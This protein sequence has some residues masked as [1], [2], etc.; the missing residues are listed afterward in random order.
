M[1]KT[2]EDFDSVIL[3]NIAH[4]LPAAKCIRNLS[5]TSRTLY[6]FVKHDGWRVF[7]LSR[8]PSIPIPKMWEDGAHA[9]TTLSRNLDRRA[10]IATELRPERPIHC[11]PTGEI[12]DSIS[13]PQGQSMGYQA[14]VDSFEEWTGNDWASRREVVAWGAGADVVLKKTMRRSTPPLENKSVARE[15]KDGTRLQHDR[16]FFKWLVYHEPSS[17]EGRDDVTALKLVQ[18]SKPQD[19]ERIMEEAVIGRANGK[20]E[21]LQLASGTS[22]CVAKSYITGDSPVRSAG[23]SKHSTPLLA[24]GFRNGQVKV[25]RVH[26]EGALVDPVSQIDCNMNSIDGSFPWSAPTDFLGSNLLGVGLGV[27]D[28]PVA[29]YDVGNQGISERPLRTFSFPKSRYSHGQ[30]I[31]TALAQFPEG[32]GSSSKAFLSGGYDGVIRLHDLRSPT[33]VSLAIHDN[34]ESSSI[35]SLLTIG[36]ERIMAGMG[37]NSL[38]NIFDMRMTGGRAYSYLDASST[39]RSSP[40]ALETEFYDSASESQWTQW[41][42]EGSRDNSILDASFGIF[43]QRSTRRRSPVY[44]LSRPSPSSPFLFVGTEGGVMQLNFTSMYDA[45]PDSVFQSG[46]RRTAKG[47]F[48]AGQTWRPEKGRGHESYFFIREQDVAGGIRLFK[49]GKVPNEVVDTLQDPMRAAQWRE[50]HYDNNVY[51]RHERRFVEGYDE[52]LIQS[53]NVD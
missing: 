52:R 36:R 9:L 51:D 38:V 27:P 45:N 12:R 47:R 4:H 35:F 18:P 26:G 21:L 7:D 48:D 24:A 8:F 3:S 29:V 17:Q 30:C 53:V 6:A 42:R 10:F 41:T 31:T 23:V 46:T 15:D 20:L 22:Q 28:T 5:L 33:D 25:Y 13:K 49:Q 11:L 1:A 2:L 50:N 32:D 16:S 39:P 14:K 40:P 43:A 44:S 19:S 34:Q 37:S